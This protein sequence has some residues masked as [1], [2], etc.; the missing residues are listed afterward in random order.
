MNIRVVIKHDANCLAPDGT[1][2]YM[3]PQFDTSLDL[4]TWESEGGTIVPE[5]EEKPQ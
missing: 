3:H 5:V 1:C 4:L 2:K